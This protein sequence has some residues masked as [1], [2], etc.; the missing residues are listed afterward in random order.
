[1]DILVRARWYR[2]AHLRMRTPRDGC[3]LIAESASSDAG[4]HEPAASRAE[5]KARPDAGPPDACPPGPKG[6]GLR[7]SAGRGRLK[8]AAPV[9]EALLRGRRRVAPWLELEAD[10]AERS[11][12][13][14]AHSAGGHSA[15][16]ESA[17][18]DAGGGMCHRQ[19]RPSGAHLRMRTPRM[20]A[21]RQLTC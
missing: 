17:S 20:G 7:D 18:S 8:R 11:A 19:R 14:D 15:I 13:E 16:V 1:M 5:R 3:D 21:G 10:A 12:S 6:A 2:G 9:S 4:G